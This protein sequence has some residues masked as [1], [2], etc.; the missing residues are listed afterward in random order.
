MS[1]LKSKK[2][3]VLLPLIV[4]LLIGVFALF[5]PSTESPADAPQAIAPEEPVSATVAEVGVVEDAHAADCAHCLAQNGPATA[6]PST[7]SELDYIFKELAAQKDK[8]IPKNTFDFFHGS[9]RGAR[10]S[11]QIANQDYSG[12]ISVVRENHELAR[13]YG[14]ALEDDLGALMVSTDAGGYLRG[15]I[16][17]NGDSRAIT[18]QE[19]QAKGNA[20]PHLVVFE[21]KVSDIF[22][23]APD[24]VYTGGGVVS[25]AESG[26]ASLA[27]GKA[28]A[29]PDADF[30]VVA[31]ESLP[32]SEYVLYLDFD[33]EVVT[34][35]LWNLEDDDWDDLETMDLDS[36]DL[37]AYPSITAL[38]QARADEDEWV[39]LVWTRVVEDFSPFNINVTT[40]R[41]TFDAADADKRVQAIITSTT[42]AAPGAG[43][44]AFI[45]SFREDSPIVW[46]FNSTEAVCAATISHE[47]GH[48]FGLTHDYEIGEIP[49]GGNDY[50]GGHNGSYT[51]GWAP[52]MGAFFTDFYYDEVNQ[53]SIGEFANS[54]ND[55]DDVAII[56]DSVDPQL[57]VDAAELFDEY[58]ENELG[59]AYYDLFFPNGVGVS[60]G[61][62]FV[63]DDHLNTIASSTEIIAVETT[64]TASGLIGTET[65]VDVFKFAA[66][67][68]DIQLVVS[69][70]DVDSSY[71][72][73]GSDSSGANLAVNT[74]L[75]DDF[76]NLLYTGVSFGA[77]E[78]SSIIETY[79]PGG[80]YYLKVDGG[81]RGDDPTTGFSDYGSLGQYSLEGDL[82]VPPLRVLGGVKRPEF[83]VFNGD[84]DTQIENGTDFGWESNTSRTFRLGNHASVADLTIASVSL[85]SGAHFDLSVVPSGTITAGADQDLKISYSPNSS[86]LHTDTVTITYEAPETLVYEFAIESVTFASGNTDNYEPNDRWGDAH[87]LGGEEDVW[88]S[89]YRGVAFFYVD[90]NDWY[91]F[92]VEE[93]DGL[94]TIDMSSPPFEGT[95][96][97][98]LVEKRG[99]GIYTLLTNTT[100]NG[101]MQY[102]IPE[103]SGLQ[104]YILVTSNG[105][106][107]TV[108]NEYDLKWS[109]EPLPDSEDDFYE[110][111]DT[112]DEAYDLTN[113]PPLSEI[114]GLGISNDEDWYKVTV[115]SNP[116][117]RL[118]YVEALFDHTQGNIDIEV[119]HEE[120]GALFPFENEFPTFSAT[121]NDTEI[122]N[123]AQLVSLTDYVGDNRSPLG[124]NLVMG[125]VPG[126]YYIRVLGDFAGNSYDLRVEPLMEDNYEVVSQDGNGDDVENDDRDNATV[127]GESIMGKWL[128]EVGGA[129]TL[130]TY[131]SDPNDLTATFVSKNDIDWYEFTISPD[132]PVRALMLEYTS[133]AWAPAITLIDA[134]SGEEVSNRLTPSGIL[135]LENPLSSTYLVSVAGFDTFDNLTGYDLRVTL[136]TEPP[137]VEDPIEDNYED[138]DDFLE[139]YNLSN[140][141]GRWLSSVDGYGTQLDPD[142]YQIS[143]PSNAAKIVA[144]LSFIEADGNMDL[145]LSKKEGPTHFVSNGGGNTETIT[146][147]DPIPG[148]YALTVTGDRRGN[149]YNLLWDITFTED[150]YEV[151]NDLATAFDLTGFESRLLSKLDGVGI[152]R[153]ADWYRI[154][155]DA[156]TVEIR[157]NATFS[158]AEGD[159]D[160]A[161]FNATG[162]AVERS[163][164][165]N[166]IE[167]IT[168]TPPAPGDYYLCVYYGDEGNEYELTWSALTQAEID[169]IPEGDDAYEENDSIGAPYV[170]AAD[171]L[172]LSSLL[173]LGIQKDE[174]W[175][176]IEIPAGN[177]G[178]RLECLF[179]DSKG[180]IDFEVYDPLGFPLFVRDSITD[181]EI[182]VVDT[183]VPTGT[184][185]IRVY[186]PNLGNEYD[187]YWT[188]FIEDVYEDN[189]NENQLYDMTLLLG[190][191]LSDFGVPTLGDNDWFEFTVSGVTPFLQVTLECINQNGAVNLDILDSNKNIIA[192]LDS[193]DDLESLP[194]VLEVSLGLHYIHVYGDFAYNPY[195][196]TVEVIGDDQYEENDVS[197]DAADISGSQLI[198][199]VQFDDDWFKFTVTDANSF[200]SIIAS[201]THANGNIDLDVYESADL[202]NPIASSVTDQNGESVS[203]PGDVGEYYIKISG[204]D[205][206]QSYQLVWGV[207]PDDQYEPN[208]NQGEAEDISG[209]EGVTI[210]AIQF[211]ADWF[212]VFVAPGNV[213]L[214]VD[215]TFLHATGDLNLT[216]YDAL[217]EEL[218]FVDTV[219]DNESLVYTTYPFGTVGESYFVKVDGMG[220]GTAYELVW[221]TSN[222]DDFEGE[223]GNN[224]FDTASTDLIG[225]EGQ[226]ISETLGYGGALNDDWY[227]VRINPGDAGIVIEAFFINSDETNIDLELF[228]PVEG[229]EG[230][231]ELAITGSYITRS[232]GVSNVERIHYKGDPGV[233]YLRVFGTSGENPYDLVWNSYQEDDL[234]VSATPPPIYNDNPDTPRN[235]SGSLLNLSLGGF[236]LEFIILDGLTQLDHDWYSVVVNPGE[237]YFRVDLE[238]EHIQGD[239][240]V[241]V[242][243]SD[244]GVLIEQAESEA[245]GEH[246]F[247]RNLGLDE[248]GN[249]IDAPVEYLICVYGYGIL[250]PKSEAGWAP[251]SHNPLVD[252]EYSTIEENADPS[253][254]YYD[255]A[256]SHARGLA[257]TYSLRWISSVE[258]EYDATDDFVLTEVNDSLATA[259]VPVLVDQDGVTD[260]DG[261]VD[262]I[263][264]G[265]TWIDCDGATLVIPYQRL[266]A[267][268]NLAQ[269]DDDWFKFT[270]N[271]QKT[272][273]AA[274]VHNSFHGNLDFT[275]YAADGTELATTVGLTSG[276]ESIRVDNSGLNTYYIKVVGNDLG[277]PYD[278]FVSGADDD[279]Y[280]PNNDLAEAAENADITDFAITCPEAEPIP[281]V[282]IQRDLDIFRV[283]VPEDQVHLSVIIQSV[284]N[285]LGV[286]VLN[287]QGDVLPSGFKESGSGGSSSRYIGG[288]IAPEAGTYYF[289]VIGGDIGFPYSLNWGYN[290]I[291]QYD[292]RSAWPIG[293]GPGVTNDTSFD[294][295]DLTRFRLE[296]VYVPVSKKGPPILD[297]IQEFAFDYGLLSGLTMGKPAYDPFGHAIQEAD[298]WYSI[299][300]PSWFLA[301]AKQGSETIEVLKRDYYVRLSAEIEFTH[302]DGDINMEIYDETN[303]ITPLGRSETPNDIESLT[304]RIDP[305]DGDRVYYIRV[306]GADAANDYSLKWDFTN[307]DAYE[308]LEDEVIENDTNNFIEI[309][310][311][312]TNADGVSTEDTWLHEI[313]YLQDVNGDGILNDGGFTSATGY[314]LQK[315]TDDWYAVVVSEGATQIFVD[316]ASFSDNDQ[317]YL[318]NPD[319]LDI[320]FE[321]YFL[322]GND[323]DVGTTDL[324]KPVLVGRSTEDTDDTQ[325]TSDGSSSEQLTVDVTT[326]IHE[327]GTFDVTETGAGI[328]F[329][330]VYYDNRSHPY[331]FY[332][333]D[334]GDTDNSGDAAIILDY[335]NGDWSFV[336]PDDLPSALLVNPNSNADGDAMPNWAEYALALNSSI[337][338][339][340]VIGQSIVEI[341]GKSYYQFEFLRRKEAVA[342]D[343]NFIVEETPDLVFDGTQ[344]VFVGTE[345]VSA[346]VERVMYRCSKSM[347]EQDQCFFRLSVEEPVAKAE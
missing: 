325:F 218:A 161:L 260:E 300:I 153:D 17:F 72:E 208:D 240:D 124:T 78:L 280:E 169:D 293:A 101:R 322:A 237:D 343:Y 46:A 185:K 276:V 294:A 152:Q 35:T 344:A 220:A 254:D 134:E 341:E 263:E 277:V 56:G 44:V 167:S 132:A 73:L 25:S 312:L 177:V 265:Y 239:I 299:Q 205:V 281:M 207:S 295:T 248:F 87:N 108:R 162:S 143:I 67:E 199:A 310:H 27:E 42:T 119:Y 214:T 71:S 173:G 242:Y 338:D 93:G 57:G 174:D 292:D 318:Y 43:G 12:R 29:A 80:T 234:E 302:I 129:G 184:Y 311:D 75:W 170:L 157:A 21:N 139:L 159:I 347:D 314:G 149:F 8:V 16:L 269:F 230:N 105:A 148:Q 107:S 91:S 77:N 296:P 298:D 130:A 64:I 3:F 79:V 146:W 10:A 180:D 232:I 315:N 289:R 235:L 221:E 303:M 23:A 334:L 163:E 144:T 31:L 209:L 14:M 142:W 197:D 135:T 279:A 136:D 165:S 1:A 84:T 290:N 68:G 125:V 175:Y 166:D 210:E 213:K 333:D 225:S 141:E 33:G 100:G 171:E 154:S 179:D 222:E 217:G 45:Y 26:M 155:A 106:D 63:A 257:N 286:E 332:W 272:F 305:T 249:P 190:A 282:F 38:P 238:F 11:I 98:Q 2:Q 316:C 55:E 65:D 329:I 85:A 181:N 123:V 229:P 267:F 151:N 224:T 201:F 49:G 186:G 178:L 301:S 32:S 76:G 195:D 121:E 223:T 246:I 120:R 308:Q 69:P 48:A 92:T 156:D 61:F 228:K 5:Q 194:E 19:L 118:L 90:H 66:N 226:K 137:F 244:S 86:G 340:A 297:P 313:E 206:N 82:A 284:G 150:N 97:F 95:V 273:W 247:I 324:R 306:Y 200:L 323:G 243:N 54:A 283:E 22:C 18:F 158:N 127:L 227:E 326:E 88:L 114:V 60:N 191:P 337:A 275:L 81:G 204:D 50:Y 335:L 140:N 211:D 288:V 261:I 251:K 41:A 262:D 255:L 51:P 346:D 70:L 319:N 330:R 15:H 117:Y 40:D 164:T 24:A 30:E 74:E 13:T 36:L 256:D 236:D 266:F 7:K 94:I 6:E 160:L 327:S 188:P 233:Y 20:E 103:G 192:T 268:E 307:E 28:L 47:A 193:T 145:S 241:A 112:K 59:D 219:T 128:S 321:V 4:A 253:F 274:I 250:N 102:L 339:T 111:N 53:W 176:Q 215:I 126:L 182:L 9:Q 245:D 189:D 317:G 203:I 110:E 116:Y 172:R 196:L 285:L 278:L 328:Y 122:V 259:A 138:N 331:T 198:N 264:R 212:E 39:E 147:E 270:V 115:P 252:G 37:V 202:I 216:L 104:Y 58:G 133:V 83:R 109:A 99:N 345:S 336:I 231:A 89:D 131:T 52:I 187:L 96:E 320:D 309:A 168:Y 342:Y 34:N 183:N 113:S 258:D 62:G 271:T 304:V 287:A 291:D